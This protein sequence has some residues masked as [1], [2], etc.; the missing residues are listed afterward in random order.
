MFSY[1]NQM[2]IFGCDCNCELSKSKRYA[3]ECSKFG[4]TFFSLVDRVAESMKRQLLQGFISD[5][6]ISR[7]YHLSACSYLDD[8]EFMLEPHRIFDSLR[9]PMAMAPI[10]H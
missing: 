10:S 8:I 4:L 3:F 1:A 9:D 6:W 7:V 2:A 5:V